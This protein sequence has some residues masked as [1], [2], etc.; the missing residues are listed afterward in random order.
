MALYFIHPFVYTYTVPVLSV[1][2]TYNNWT[3]CTFVL[4][5]AFAVKSDGTALLVL[6]VYSHT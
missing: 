2:S 3:D 4:P 5:M 1:F 6:I